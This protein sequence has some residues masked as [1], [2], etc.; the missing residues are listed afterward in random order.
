M[1]DR[2]WT[3]TLNE[4]SIM[5]YN[6]PIRRMVNYGQNETA[7]FNSEDPIGFKAFYDSALKDI[8]YN[9]LFTA[10]TWTA[11]YAPIRPNIS[12][13]RGPGAD[14]KAAYFDVVNSIP[15]DTSQEQRLLIFYILALITSMYM[16][17]VSKITPS[18]VW[19]VKIQQYFDSENVKIFLTYANPS[20]VISSPLGQGNPET[21]IGNVSIASEE[22]LTLSGDKYDVVRPIAAFAQFLNQFLQ[23][24]KTSP[25][26]D[27]QFYPRLKTAAFNPLDTIATLPNLQ[28]QGQ[29]QGRPA[30][31][32]TAPTIVATKPKTNWPMLALAA[33]AI[34]LIIWKTQE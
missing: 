10:V 1:H 7:A 14:F 28:S 2:L 23:K 5:Y 8:P 27:D 21:A 19:K 22:I 20:A 9:R 26:T 29:S 15:K 12:Y 11:R 4:K 24:E 16:D 32:K 6:A 18:N 17:A 25:S 33:A 30:P 13:K 3:E 31:P 34:G